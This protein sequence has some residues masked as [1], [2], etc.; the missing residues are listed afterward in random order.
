MAAITTNAPASTTPT[1][2]AQILTAIL[3][4]GQVVMWCVVAVGLFA[5]IACSNNFSLALEGTGS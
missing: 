5:S 3:V 4:G 1:A 2:N